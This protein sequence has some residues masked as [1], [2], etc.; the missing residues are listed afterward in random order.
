MADGKLYVGTENGRFFIIRPQADRAEVLSDVLMPISTNSV[1]GSEGT[2]EQIVSG[3]AISRGR[4]FFVTSD[5]VYAVGPRAPKTLTGFAVDEPAIKGD[6]APAY[7]QVSPTEITLQPGETAKLR[8]R[9]FDAQ[10]AVPPRGA[11]A[12]WS[13]QGLK[14]TVAAGAF[15]AAKDMEDQAGVVRADGRRSHRRSADRDRAP[16]RLDREFRG[17]RGGRCACRA[18][19]TASPES[20]P[21]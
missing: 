20:S 1:G 16:G 19:S 7:V 18:G 13:L 2:P 14:G 5:A 8:A 10:G 21:S 3:A 9:L 12:T 4:V 17:L 15:T 6:G 11:A